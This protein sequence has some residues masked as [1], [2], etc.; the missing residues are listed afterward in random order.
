[1]KTAFTILAAILL[2][3]CAIV[4]VRTVFHQP[5]TLGIVDR[6]NIA[7][8]DELVG[9][10]LSEAIRF[11]T[12][13]FQNQEDSQGSEFTAFIDWVQTTYP[14]VHQ[15][16]QLTRLGGFTL[17]FR[18]QG[19]DPT[20][21][22]IL[23]TGHYDVVPVIPGSEEQ[24]QHPPFSGKISDGVIWG[25]GALDDKSA[26]IAQLEA[27]THLLNSGF[28]PQRTVYFSFGHDEEVGGVNGA[29]KVTAFLDEKDVQLA[30]SLDEGSFLFD[31][32]QPGVEQLN[33]AVNVA[34]K[35]SVTLNI[36]ATS[37]GGHSSMP[38]QQTAVG[39]LAEAI[40]ALESNPVPGGLTGLSEQMFDTASRYMPFSSRVFFANRWLFDSLVEAQL[41]SVTFS[42]AMLRTTTAPTMLSGSVKV[43]VL[44]IEAIATVNFRLHP[45]DSV[46][47][48]VTYVESI[49]ASDAVE[50]R[51]PPGSGRAAS[52]VSSWESAG[53]RV[54]EQ[55]I[56]E[57]FGDVVVTPGLMIAG[58]DSRHYG[59]VAD[60]AFRFNPF[61]VTQEDMT[62]F[63]GTNEKISLATLGQGT[64][65]YVR[66]LELGASE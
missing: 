28:S 2:L 26:V 63:H 55:S 61:T 46:E 29:A 14:E 45:R 51:L 1:M 37:A 16:M 12:V 18:W 39:L 41:S 19:S 33:A 47:S 30:W 22:P 59:K 24:W 10:H 15:S 53:Y 8:D 21:Q 65:T 62:G 64:R 9:R 11:R 6:V 4:V 17:L 13:S 3:V 23:L 27:A 7:L 48:L 40:T 34:E 54:V 42:N 32:L 25:R 52:P 38:P 50:V 20:L 5:Q 36:V 58:S 57:T 49:V 31:G 60:N 56:R 35:G 43:N 66:I 44:P